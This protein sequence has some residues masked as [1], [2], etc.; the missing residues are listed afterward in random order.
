MATKA[1]LNFFQIWNMC[2]GFFGIQIG[3]GLQNANTSRIFQSLGV[4]VNQLAILWIAAPATGLLVQPII[5]YLSDKTWGRLGRRRPYFFWGAI[6]TSAALL[7]MPNAP[8]LWIAA[9]AL[10]VMDASINITM[11]PFRAFVGDNLPDEQRA[12]GYAM[13]SFFIGTGAVLASALPWM[14]TRWFGI[15]NAVEGG[16]VPLSVHIAFY[17]GAAGVLL[18]VLWTVFTTREYSPD[19][20]AAFEAAERARKG[21]APSMAADTPTRAVRAYMVGGVVWT[22][23]GVVLAVAIFATRLEKEVYVL[24]AMLGAFGLAQIA[25]GLLRR[26]GKTANGFSEVVED[27]F[28]MP[29]TMKQ[30]AVVQFFSW[31]GLFA[32]WIYTT[33][34]VTAF[35]YHA[36]DTASRAY[37]DG[38]DWVGV[39][40]ALYNGVAALAALVIPLIARAVGRKASH[41][42]CLGLGGLGLAAFPLIRDPV[43]L[44]IPMIGVGFAWSSILSAPYSIL[45][46]AVPGPK[47][48]VYMGIF[49]FFIV[50]PQ[51]LAAT[52]LGVLLKTFFDGQAIWA[53]I[54]G[55]G[56]MLAAA[57]CVFLVR[58]V[59]EPRALAA[60]AP[61]PEALSKA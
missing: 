55:G 32:L 12:S 43:L 51:L 22:L 48:G 34:A 7:V 49:N 16:G 11:E 13:Q 29:D 31:F 5:G 28:R 41:A 19:Q 18:A 9:A 23:A 39:L 21:E 59:G 33:P 37:N 52:I 46:G 44:W 4:E 25:A 6:L 58:D 20:M 24:A 35:H 27:L 36:T 50:I 47:M 17:V 30:L 10:W 2:F 56:S 14:L 54:L 45:S 38:A 61:S 1:R 15:S 40:F 57:A 53:L 42:L 60:A 26:G 8:V 3:F